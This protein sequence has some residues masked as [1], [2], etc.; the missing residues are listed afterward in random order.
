MRRIDA[1]DLRT[2][3]VGP[4]RGDLCVSRT[5]R[6]I[7]KFV[8]VGVYLGLVGFVTSWWLLRAADAHIEASVSQFGDDLV[9][10]LDP[11][12]LSSPQP[13]VVNGQTMYLSSLEVAQPLATTL[14][15]LQDRCKKW[16][17][18]ALSGVGRLPATVAGLALA[19]ELRDPVDWAVNRQDAPDETSGQV[20]CIAPPQEDA[21]LID[22][23]ARIARF[24]ETG[25]LAEVGNARYFLARRVSE[26]R[27]HV[28]AIWTEGSFDL[29]GMF[30]AEGDA[31][32]T[33]SD[34]A[35]RPPAARRIFSGVVPNRPYAARVYTSR[36]SRREVLA[37]YDATLSAKGW[38]E[39]PMAAGDEL[40]VLTR[41][42]SR[43]G[44]LVFVILDGTD[45]AE[46]PVTLVEMNGEGFAASRVEPSQGASE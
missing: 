30:P 8:R 1:I 14:G 2:R 19:P 37:H 5:S 41:A 43:D 40:R 38:D 11:G 44:K 13:V 12:L 20:A 33:D 16:V 46:T 31:P 25:D 23:L 42:F 36:A 18:P 10:Q 15:H 22:V 39:Q 21:A 27:T 7:V 32:G 34:L 45:E 4:S 26:S 29:L 3:A 28:L 24:A 17:S 35:P 6:R 9:R